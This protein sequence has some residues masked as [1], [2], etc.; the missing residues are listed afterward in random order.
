M[1]INYATAAPEAVK[2]IYGLQQYVSQAGLEPKLVLLTQLRASQ[3]NGC[4]FCM[5]MHAIELRELGESDVRIDC[6]SSW[7]ETDLFNDRE[8]AALAWTETLT[9]LD[10]ESACDELYDEARKHFDEKELIG[11]T[12]AVATINVWNRLNVAF[13]TDPNLAPAVIEQAKAA[14]RGA[15]ALV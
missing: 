10:A 3:M 12:M 7:S 6:I 2:R 14:R 5:H 8:R 11:L 9:R 4:A 13:R 15:A 1:R